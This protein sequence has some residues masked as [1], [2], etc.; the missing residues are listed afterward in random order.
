MKSRKSSGTV[1]A[2][3]FEGSKSNHWVIRDSRPG[4]AR[5]LP[6]GDYFEMEAAVAAAEVAKK[7][8]PRDLRVLMGNPQEG[9]Y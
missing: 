4:A 3:Y 8:S 2:M 5:S 9:D 6:L 1:E 7:L